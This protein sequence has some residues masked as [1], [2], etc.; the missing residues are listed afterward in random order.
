MIEFLRLAGQYLP[1]LFLA[2]LKYTL[3]LTAISFSIGVV[4]A[5]MVA[6]IRIMKQPQTIMLKWGCN[7]LQ[8]F[9]AFYVWVFRSTPMIV[10]LFIVFYGLPN[11]KI[12][13]FSNAWISAITV[14]SLNTGAYASESIRAAILSVDHGQKEAA[15]SM[16]L[17][18]RQAYWHIILPQAA[19]IAVPPL[20]N[21]LIS[22][23]KDTSLASVITIVETFY[24]SQQI[25]AQNYR[26]LSM[27]L[28]VAFIYATITTI[29]TMGQQFLE[30]YASRYLN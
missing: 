22:L 29:L 9:A 5:T 18:N 16:G 23:V 12:D 27:Y 24:L 7:F 11:A 2:A 4:I 14:F 20:S 6:M 30:L 26:I 17:N 8:W 28:L 3:P 25:A 21:S 15:L 1:E 13:F 19:R 10:Q